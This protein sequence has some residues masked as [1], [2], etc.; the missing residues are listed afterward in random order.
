MQLR[1]S[2]HFGRMARSR[3][4][5]VLLC[6]LASQ[7]PPAAAD[8]TAEPVKSKAWRLLNTEPVEIAW[9]VRNLQF[10]QDDNCTLA[11]EAAPGHNGEAFGTEAAEMTGAEYSFALR[12]P[13]GWESVD[14]CSHGTCHLGFRWQQE[15]SVRCVLF[16]QGE[17]GFHAPA[18]ALEAQSGATGEWAQVAAW[19]NVSDGRAKLAAACP[20]H[21]Q[22]VR[23]GKV[24]DCSVQSELLQTCAVSCDPGFGT[25]EPIMRC[26]NGVWYAPECHSTN[27][28][29]R[30]V[31]KGPEIIKPYWVV[32]K[33]VFYASA[34]CTDVIRMDGQAFSSG[35]YV[36]KY[37]NYH[38]KNVWDGDEGT[39]WASATPCSPHGC[40]FGFRFRKPP[41]EIKCLMVEHPDGSQYHADHVLLEHLGEEGWEE[42]QDLT[43]RLLPS[44]KQ[45]L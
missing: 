42:V 4:A 11:L 10:Y 19:K 24:S 15:V 9:R 21:Q 13:R 28:M 14:E 44:G 34:D 18:V 39:S 29:Y 1:A 36:V 12:S 20:M 6:L 40:F 23:H 35:E 2:V 45:E 7:S 43:I 27:T 3:V 30:V 16:H 17:D 26:I 31:A 32:L 37:A 41:P 38:P 33:A 5:S 25:Q 22:T 8:R